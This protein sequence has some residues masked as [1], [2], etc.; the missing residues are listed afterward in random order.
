MQTQT[1]STIQRGVVITRIFDAPRELIWK[2][3]TEPERVKRWWGP[4]TFTTPIVK[5]DLR[6]GGG[7]FNCMRSPE[8]KDYCSKGTYKEIAEPERLVSSDSFADAK[9]NVVPATY[10]GMDSRWPLEARLDVTFEDIQGKTKMTLRYEGIAGASEQ[11]LR[12]M[13]QGWNEQ[14]DKLVE[15]LRNT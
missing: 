5:I 4:K 9:G 7:Y 15:Y 1:K 6:V 2:A 14:F 3:W 8:G 13:E 11:D 10:Y 12:N